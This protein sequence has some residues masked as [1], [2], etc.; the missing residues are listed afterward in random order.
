MH[1]TVN[2]PDLIAIYKTLHLT[3]VDYIFSL[4]T[5]DTFAKIECIWGH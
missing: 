2:Q 5:H 3:A 4:L 1:N